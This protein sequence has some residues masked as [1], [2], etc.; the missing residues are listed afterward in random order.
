MEETTG[1][2]LNDG[3]VL[4]LLLS[5]LVFALPLLSILGAI[6]AAYYGLG[7]ID[8]KAL[9][10][11]VFVLIAVGTWFAEARWARRGGWKTVAVAGVPLAVFA[12]IGVVMWRAPAL[13]GL[14]G[15]SVGVAP[16]IIGIVGLAGL[17]VHA[18][19]GWVAIATTPLRVAGPVV[20]TKP[21]KPKKGR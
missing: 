7:A 12:L 2:W 11:L 9:V 14:G 17:V 1:S 18:V 20:A 6:L 8:W 19:F 3:L 21:K 5:L 15:E 4:A 16:S 13:L 10:G